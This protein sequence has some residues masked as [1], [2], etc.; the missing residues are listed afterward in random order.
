MS[1]PISDDAIGREPTISLAT[2]AGVLENIEH[3]IV[4]LAPNSDTCFRNSAA[5]RILVADAE[6]GVIVR[7]MG[8]VFRAALAYRSGRAAEAM[9]ATQGARYRMRATLLRHRIHEIGNHPVLVTI[10]R[11][12]ANS[13]TPVSV[14]QRFGMTPREA[15][16]AM[17]L[18][19]GK[20][21]SEIAV[22]LRISKHTARHHTENV[23]L[24]LNVHARSEVTS[25]IA[26]GLDERARGSSE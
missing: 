7:E 2:L 21:N 15:D 4:L 22:E 5:E 11:A 16:V 18:S 12:V 17:L 20:R 9:V 3:G 10:Q 14:I 19:R 1:L 24:K 25:A 13:P 26:T 23:M 8:S 6:H